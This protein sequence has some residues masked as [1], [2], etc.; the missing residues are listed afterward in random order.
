MKHL[1][2]ASLLFLM[3][4]IS[5]GAFEELKEAVKF[6]NSKG[7]KKG[8]KSCVNKVEDYLKTLIT[9]GERKNTSEK[10]YAN[11]VRNTYRECFR[12]FIDASFSGLCVEAKEL[13]SYEGDDR[14]EKIKDWQERE[15]EMVVKTAGAIRS[16]EY[17]MDYEKPSSSSFGE[18]AGG[19]IGSG[20][21]GAV[22]LGTA[23][24]WLGGGLGL[25]KGATKL[26]KATGKKEAVPG[27]FGTIG[28]GISGAVG[29]TI[30][31]GAIGA[32]GGLAVGAISSAVAEEGGIIG[33]LHRHQE[34]RRHL[35]HI[36]L[37][38]DFCNVQYDWKD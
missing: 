23:G 5:L 2:I 14:K 7:P 21:S 15:S 16:Y 37:F 27:L 24:F 10:G 9:E 12:G 19:V 26:N 17:S 8:L 4:T 11:T 13:A 3:P 36:L 6:D 32:V 31:G 38:N 35:T 34:D 18:K 33:H 20:L 1:M 25:L 29:G 28:G 22:M 30:K